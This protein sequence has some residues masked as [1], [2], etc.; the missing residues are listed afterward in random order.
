VN[1]TKLCL[2]AVAIL[3][4][5]CR[6]LEMIGAYFTNTASLA[7]SGSPEIVNTSVSTSGFLTT[8]GIVPEA[9]GNF[10]EKEENQGGANVVIISNS[11]W[12]NRFGAWRDLIGQTLSLDGKSQEIIGVLPARFQFPF[13][14]PAPDV[15]MPRIV[16]LPERVLRNR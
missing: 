5:K 15:W 8:L 9:N 4:A 12:H 3:R 2:I 7:T 1:G 6:S 11:F 16:F 13:A 14:E 10:S